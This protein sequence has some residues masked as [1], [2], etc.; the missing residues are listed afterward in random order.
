MKSISPHPNH[1]KMR[2]LVYT[3]HPG[4]S[5]G[6]R[7]MGTPRQPSPTSTTFY[8]SSSRLWQAVNKQHTAHCLCFAYDQKKWKVQMTLQQQSC[9]I[10][11]NH[12]LNFLTATRNNFQRGSQHKNQWRYSLMKS[13]STFNHK[14]CCHIMK[15]VVFN[16]QGKGR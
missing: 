4:N 7:E 10:S 9:Q 11:C 16:L 5:M 12:E 6:R 13:F 2:Y 1:P 15:K 14:P 8:L 3:T